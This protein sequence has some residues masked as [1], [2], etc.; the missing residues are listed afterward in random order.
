MRTGKVQFI[1]QDGVWNGMNKHKVTMA[2][3]NVYTFFSKGDFKKSVGDEIK[4]EITNEQYGNAKLVREN[5]YQQNGYQQ[6]NFQKSGMPK[7]QQIIRQ[8]C[9]KASA[10]FNAGRGQASI[11]EVIADAEILLNWV[12][13]G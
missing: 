3:G 8:T 11:Q 2:D 13:N 9:I 10:E 4:F 6:N 1:N 7:D 12:N 5:N